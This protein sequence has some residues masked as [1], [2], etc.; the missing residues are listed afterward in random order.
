MG[1]E[2]TDWFPTID[3]AKCNGCMACVKKCTHGVYAK[4]DGKPMVVRPHNCIFGCTG[5]QPI[6]PMN[7][8]THP[9]KERHGKIAKI[10]NNSACCCECGKTQIKK[11]HRK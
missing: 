2:Q 11:K 5:C 8:I 10:N 4:R 7:A 1:Y 6:C 9:S 3:Y